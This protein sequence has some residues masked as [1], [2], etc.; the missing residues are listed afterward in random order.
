MSFEIIE[1]NDIM[2][3]MADNIKADNDAFNKTRELIIANIF[4]ISDDYF[5]D[6]SFG[7]HW[8]NIRH[9]LHDALHPLCPVSYHHMSVNQKGGMKFNYDFVIDYC[10]AKK[11]VLHA[12]KV[13]FKNN[14]SNVKDLVQFL[15]LYDKDC[16]AAFGMFEYSYSE[17]YYDHFL[18]AYLAIDEETVAKP[19]KQTYLQHVYD[20]KYKHP[21][22]KHLYDRKTNNKKLKDKLVEESR[23]QFISTYVNQFQFDKITQKI[24]ESQTNK[25]FLLWDKT[26][27]HI[28]TLDVENIQISGIKPDSINKLYFDVVVANF[29][30]DIRIRLNWGNNNGVANPRWKFS[31]IDK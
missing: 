30:Y 6:P 7:Q 27:F 18:D 28:E 11:K 9:R 21:F 16:K 10:D 4:T 24:R 2:A 19:E 14:N 12:V 25:V 31:F 23:T 29:M 8:S 17:F 5:Q 13:E 26:Q 3:F 1:T 15:E 20:I 22:F